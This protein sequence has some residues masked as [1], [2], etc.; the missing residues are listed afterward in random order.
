M[1]KKEKKSVDIQANPETGGMTMDALT[2]DEMFP[3]PDEEAIRA[4]SAQE[5][6][7]PQTMPGF[8]PEIHASKADGTPSLTKNGNFRKKTKS[9]FV[10]PEEKRAEVAKQAAMEISSK[11]A[12]IVCSGLIEQIS[13]KLISDEFAYSDLER[14]SNVQAW[15]HCFD[16]YGGVNLTPPA[17]LALNHA[18]I[19]LTRLG[20]PK[21]MGKFKQIGGWMKNKFKRKPKNGALLNRGNDGKRQD[22]VG[23]E[24]S[25]QPAKDGETHDNS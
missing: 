20:Q 25:S 13:V 24:K 19:V 6:V 15:E 11:E 2:Q 8:D 21:T 9:K 5:N 16:H 1:S 17:A 18:A 3:V 22:N 7:K 14:G 4:I 10:K 12:A 23:A